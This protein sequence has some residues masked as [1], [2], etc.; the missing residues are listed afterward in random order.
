VDEAHEDDVEQKLVQHE[1]V[2]STLSV[3]DE[4][5]IRRL[6]VPRKAARA[7]IFMLDNDLSK[8]FPQGSPCGASVAIGRR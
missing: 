6:G 7:A 4:E 3:T 1:I 2:E 8:G 5:M